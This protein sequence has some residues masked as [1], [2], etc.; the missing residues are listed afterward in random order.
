MIIAKVLSY[1]ELKEMTKEDD[2]IIRDVK[3]MMIKDGKSDGAMYV[4]LSVDNGERLRIW[5]GA[6]GVGLWITLNF[7]C[8]KSHSIY[9]T[10]GHVTFLIK[11]D[12]ASS[13]FVY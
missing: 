13:T 12:E 5:R 11:N 2:V 1:K 8:T 7:G 10:R 9:F 3:E 4:R 6:D